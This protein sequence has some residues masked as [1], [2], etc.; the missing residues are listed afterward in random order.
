[1]SSVQ[2]QIDANGYV[3]LAVNGYAE[4]VALSKWLPDL[5]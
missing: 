3:S 2:E 1:M 5:M 4:M